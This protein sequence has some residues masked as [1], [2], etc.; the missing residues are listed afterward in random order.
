MNIMLLS[1]PDYLDIQ[2]TIENSYRFSFAWLYLILSL[3]VFFY[4][5]NDYFISAFKGLR[6]KIINIDVPIAL[7]ILALFS[8]SIWEVVTQTGTGYFDSMSGLVFFLLIGKWYQG[9]TYQALSFERDYK[10]YFPVAVTILDELGR[11]QSL[12]LKDL[13]IGQRILVRNQEIHPQDRT[14]MLSVMVNRISQYFTVIVLLIATGA[15]VAWLFIDP[16]VALNAFTSVLIAACPCALALTIPFAFGNAMRV[17]GRS[18]LYLRRTEVIEQLTAID[19]VVFDKTGTITQ[20]DQFDV[21]ATALTITDEEREAIHALTRQSTHPM[22]IAIY[23][24]SVDSW[25]LAVGSWQ[26]AI[27]SWQ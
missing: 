14:S 4:A 9:K 1:F 13:K 24:W 17:F 11:E 6:K 15:G 10:S 19:T 25:Q 16:S 21:D 2:G 26:L 23:G 18:G 22:S 27:G 8:R 5:G 7:G 12:P 20:G 3:P